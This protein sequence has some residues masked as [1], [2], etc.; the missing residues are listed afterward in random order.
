M[1]TIDISLKD[2]SKLIGKEITRENLEAEALL[3]VKGEI[4]G[5]EGDLL[6]IDCKESNRPDLWSTEGMARA[7]APFYTKERGIRKYT[8]E[9]SDLYIHVDRSVDEVRPFITAAVISDITITEELLKQLIQ[10]QEK[11]S[12]TFGRK[13]KTVGLGIYDYDKISA[14]LTYKACKPTEIKYVPLGCTKEMTLKEVLEKHPKGIEYAH[15]LKGYERYPVIID[16]NNVVAS[17]PPITNSETTGKVTEKTK[18]LFLEVTGTNLEDCKVALNVMACALADRGGKIHSV[19]IDYGKQKIVTPDFTPKKAK[20]RIE[21]EYPSFRQDILHP[22]DVIEDIPISYGFNTIKPIIPD[23]STR[24]EL[25]E[26]ELFCESLRNVLPGFGAQELLNFTLTNKEVLFKKM[27]SKEE[28]CVE[29][30]NPVSSKWS[31]I[32]NTILP[33]LMEFFENN[34]TQEYP[35]QI[36]ELGECVI[37]DEKAE[38]RTQTIK[39][40]AWALAEKEANFTK[41]KQILE[42]ILKG[43]NMEYEIEAEEHESF[44]SGRCAGVSIKGT[45]IAFVGEIHPQVLKNFSLE[46]PVCAFELNVSEIY[47]LKE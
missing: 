10:L 45:K 8:S 14:P 9:F 15:L 6:K 7:L 46:F 21:V 23:I 37:I 29:I 40:L 30:A 22:V 11:V 32:R 27:N 39:H 33:S 42:Y 31:C 16:K 19:T 18:N 4:D 41:A 17:M 43:L 25:L 28:N 44:I 1:P 34:Q 12:M 38:T 2:L 26:S 20:D 3:W 36:Y 24:G 47:K 5:E 13:R 35:Q